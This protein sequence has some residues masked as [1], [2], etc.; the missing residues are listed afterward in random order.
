MS[1]ESAECLPP[2]ENPALSIPTAILTKPARITPLARA[3]IALGLPSDFQPR[4]NL[5]ATMRKAKLKSSDILSLYLRN[6]SREE[7][8]AMMAQYDL[9]MPIE[10]RVV[11]L[12]HLLA[13][14]KLDYHTILGI[15][16]EEVS[17]CGASVATIMAGASH[18]ATMNK[19]IKFA[20]TVEGVAD[21]RLLHELAGTKAIPRSQTTIFNTRELRQT[22]IQMNGAIPTLA[23]IGK[24]LEGVTERTG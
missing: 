6:S 12:D 16:V 21:R 20:H 8:R 4:T 19:T 1:P 22:N 9:L 3:V 15:I 24:V 2:N 10:R 17:R 14:C 23:D 7:A 11:T 13:A 18:P 5:T